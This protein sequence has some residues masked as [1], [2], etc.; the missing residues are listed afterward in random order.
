MNP[1]SNVKPTSS[2]PDFVPGILIGETARFF[3]LP[4]APV[5]SPVAIRPEAS[6]SRYVSP[7]ATSILP[8]NVVT[9]IR[10]TVHNRRTLKLP[11]NR[12]DLDTYL[13][14]VVVAKNH[15]SKV[16]TRRRR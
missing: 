13:T 15:K 4:S 6:T 8:K 12:D 14:N 7:P 2:V 5:V 9:P 1:S 3:G 11:N 16:N 10:A